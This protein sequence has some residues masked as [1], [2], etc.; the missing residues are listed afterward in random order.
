MDAKNNV[1]AAQ[2]CMMRQGD[3][4]IVPV[5]SLPA[6]LEP[7]KREKGRVVL[8]HGEVTGHAHA[9][10]D[11][12]VTAFR[13]EKLNQLFLHA[14]GEQVGPLKG[15]L[16]EM[17]RAQGWFLAQTDLRKMPIKFALS[18]A[19]IEDGVIECGPFSLL[20][21]EEHNPVAIPDG[22]HR[23]IRQR[24]YSPEAIRNVA[25]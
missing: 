4:L 5:S 12:N 20:D 6:G 18:H 1:N 2:S 17:D 25:D 3:V 11:R 15:T 19:Q 23:I 10:K 13:D 7:V 9:I 16:V 14:R 22:E 24:E 21:H 8:A